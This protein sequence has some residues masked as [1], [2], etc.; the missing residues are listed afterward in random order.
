MKRI[1][2]KYKKEFT[3]LQRNRFRSS[4]QL[5]SLV[6]MGLYF[7]GSTLF[8]LAV[9]G[10]LPGH[11]IFSLSFIAVTSIS[12]FLLSAQVTLNQ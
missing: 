11:V 9:Y 2:D 5:F 3:E 10:K 12:I 7:V 1:P 6:L 4:V 8:N